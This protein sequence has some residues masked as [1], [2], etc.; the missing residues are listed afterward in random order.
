MAETSVPTALRVKQWDDNYFSEYIRSNRY[1]RYMGTSEGSLIQMREQGGKRKGDQIIFQLVNR[2]VGSG[3]TNNQTLAGNEE[4]LSQRSFGVTV[5]LY[6]HGVVVPE[7]EEYASPID[8]RNAARSVLKDWSLE[9][10]RDK[11]TTALGAIATS[12]TAQVAYASAS[13]AE[14]NAWNVN[15]VDRVLFGAAKSNYSAT[16]STALGNVDSTSDKLT[17]DAIS[18]MKRIAKT[19]SPKVRPIRVNG[20][21]EWYVMFANSLAFRDLKANS[22]MTQANREARERGEGNPLFT[23]GDLLWD[24]VIIREIP[25]IPVISGVGASSI[26]VGPVYLCGAQAVAYALAQRWNSRTKNE[27]DYGTKFGVAIQ[28]IYEINKIVFGSGAD[29]TT[30]PKDNGVVTGFFSAVA[31]A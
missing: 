25:E 1:A 16:H 10:T 20:D 24:G 29:D 13:A 31:D 19:A 11:I 8:L 22:T 4:D 6:R 28:Q 2:L 14:K 9:H 5:N 18:L 21:E 12:T 15:N 7:Y 17:P 3:K 30:T 23:D 26:D 27:D